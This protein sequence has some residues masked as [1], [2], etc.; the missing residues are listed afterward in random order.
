MF[1]QQHTERKVIENR[2]FPVEGRLVHN[3]RPENFPCRI[4]IG[5]DGHGHGGKA[6]A[7]GRAVVRRPNSFSHQS[8]SLSLFDL[9]KP[10]VDKYDAAILG[11]KYICWTKVAV[12]DA[13]ILTRGESLDDL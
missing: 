7:L 2:F 10:E 12:N 13:G 1:G 4:Q 8:D 3:H 5:L 9:A 11:Y 6:G